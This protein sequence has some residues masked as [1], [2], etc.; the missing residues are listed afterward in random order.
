MKDLNNYILSFITFIL[1]IGCSVNKTTTKHAVC[2]EKSPLSFIDTNYNY[3]E[4]NLSNSDTINGGAIKGKVLNE[5]S[6]GIP[7]VNVALYQN[8]NIKGGAITDFDGDFKI[9]N[10]SEGIYD[11]KALY[12]GY[13]TYTLKKLV[14]K[15]GEMLSLG[16]FHIILMLF[17]VGCNEE[18]IIQNDILLTII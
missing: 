6:N 5:T 16:E 13:Q 12:V 17:C 14:I 8:G 4:L 9:S 10:V 15:G 3:T 18:K 1:V 11:L 7:F 2:D